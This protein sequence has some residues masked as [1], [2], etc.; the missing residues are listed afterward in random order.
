MREGRMKNITKNNDWKI[1]KFDENLQTDIQ[2]P[3]EFQS[4]KHEEN[5]TKTHYNCSK[6]WQKK[7]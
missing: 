4:Q 1:S 5:Y 2:W 3:S 6:L 7:Y